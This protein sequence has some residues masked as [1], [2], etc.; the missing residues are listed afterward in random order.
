MNDGNALK[1]AK[2]LLRIALFIL[3]LDE[4]EISDENVNHTR[5]RQ[6][7]E[8]TSER[9]YDKY[10]AKHKIRNTTPVY[11][12]TRVK[13]NGR[14]QY[15]YTTIQAGQDKLMLSQRDKSGSFRRKQD[16]WIYIVDDRKEIPVFSRVHKTDAPWHIHDKKSDMSRKKKEEWKKR[17]KD[18]MDLLNPGLVE[19]AQNAYESLSDTEKDVIRAYTYR[20]L[21]DINSAMLNVYLNNQDDIGEIQMMEAK[22]RIRVHEKLPAFYGMLWRGMNFKNNSALN[23]FVLKWKHGKCPLT[24]FISTT[25]V[26]KNY[27]LYF[28]P[29]QLHCVIRIVDSKNGKYIGHFSSTPMDEEVLYSCNQRFRLVKEGETKFNPIERKDGITFITVKEETIIN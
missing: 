8:F 26:E 5:E 1:F 4:S 15:H 6:A 21:Y 22:H 28:D 3:E 7:L 2:K 11:I 10:R 23:T 18:D 13:K 25:Y 14:Y 9:Q 17:C 24:G 20:D 12:R 16:G 29:D 19:E 27:S